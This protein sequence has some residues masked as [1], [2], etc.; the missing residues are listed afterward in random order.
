MTQD[1]I[2]GESDIAVS[3]HTTENDAN[4]NINPLGDI[5]NSFPLTQT[6]FI[7]IENTTTGCFILN[8]FD[9]NISALTNFNQPDLFIVCDDDSDGDETNGLGTFD[10]NIKSQGVSNIL[11][12]KNYPKVTWKSNA[13][14][15]SK[16][17]DYENRYT[18]LTYGYESDKVD[19]LSLS[20]DD[21]ELIEEVRWVSYRQHFF[22]SIIVPN[23]PF[24][25][26][27]M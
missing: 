19:Y 13:F 10:F 22:S 1:I 25:K 23:S 21:E 8:E 3:Y 27:L 4:I 14:R 9:I 2:N 24:D 7:R 20:G 15:N 18:E 16:S 26:V 11:S 6:V 5:F 17:I 12:S